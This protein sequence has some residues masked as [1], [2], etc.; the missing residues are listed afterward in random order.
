MHK[1]MI[2]YSNRLLQLLFLFHSICAS[3]S[4]YDV[5]DVQLLMNM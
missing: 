3:R 4:R 2:K 5:Y 1:E